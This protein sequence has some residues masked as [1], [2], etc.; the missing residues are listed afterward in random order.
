MTEETITIELTPQQIRRKR[1][2]GEPILP[3]DSE[4][5][6]RHVISVRLENHVGALNRVVNLFSARSFNLESVTVGETEDPDVSR[7]TLVTSGTRRQIKQVLR[8]LGKLLDTLSV[9]ELDP[10]V[11][12]ER[13]LC[14]LKVGYAADNRAELMDIAEIFRAKVVNVTPAS[15]TF[16]VTGPTSKVNAFIGMMKPHGIVEVARSGR[17]AM[18]R[19]LAYEH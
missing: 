5:P 2:N 7:L 16:E 1:A 8:L 17:V 13:E 14:L 18:H 10:D 12:I 11:T 19:E 3:E 6:G 9:E 4:A 15:M